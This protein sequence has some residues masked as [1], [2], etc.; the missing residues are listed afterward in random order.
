MAAQSGDS[1]LFGPPQDVQLVLTYPQSGVGA[2]I[3]YVEITCDQSSNLGDA[4]VVDGGIGQRSIT[5]VVEA[6]HTT[7][8][9][10][11]AQIYGY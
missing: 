2:I 10:Y 1:Q 4:Y 7:F 9:T 5:I 6:L 8:F 11:V 3:S